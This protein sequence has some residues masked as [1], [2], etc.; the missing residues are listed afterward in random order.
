MYNKQ[1]CL[2]KTNM[3]KSE[4]RIVRIS[5]LLSSLFV[6]LIPFLFAWFYLIFYFCCF[7]LGIVP[8]DATPDFSEIGKATEI[9]SKKN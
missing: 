9:I 5:F 2:S 4:K 8:N 1:H 6:L 7:Q 3:T